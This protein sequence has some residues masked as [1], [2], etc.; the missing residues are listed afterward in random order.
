MIFPG[1]LETS[2]AVINVDI[3]LLACCGHSR[4]DANSQITG[5]HL[6]DDLLRTTE[7]TIEGPSLLSHLTAG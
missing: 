3:S 4:R 7:R 2:L 1:C 6:L 5:W